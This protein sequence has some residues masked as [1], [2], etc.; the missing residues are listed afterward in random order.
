MCLCLLFPKSKE[1]IFHKYVQSL[2]I[3][4][5]WCAVL[6][7]LYKMAVCRIVYLLVSLHWR[8]CRVCIGILNI[9]SKWEA[10]IKTFLTEEKTFTIKSAL[11]S[12]IKGTQ[13][14]RKGWKSRSTDWALGLKNVCAYKSHKM[15]I[16]LQFHGPISALLER[17]LGVRIHQEKRKIACGACYAIF[18]QPHLHLHCV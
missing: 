8:K 18:P 12:G 13:L 16:T 4:C 3:L 1:N 5:M 14:F 6:G 2:C 9:Y 11:K 7:P 17:N 15:V 10:T